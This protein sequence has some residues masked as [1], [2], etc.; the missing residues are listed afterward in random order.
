MNAACKFI[1]S[2][3]FAAG[4]PLLPGQSSTHYRL[5]AASSQPTMQT[6]QSTHYLVEGSLGNTCSRYSTNSMREIA[7]GIMIH[8][9]PTN[10]VEPLF[11]SD[12]D[13]L[14][15]GWEE[16]Y[17]GNHSPSASADPDGDGFTNTQ[18]QLAGTNPLDPTSL[19]RTT[20][21]TKSGTTINVS[22][23]GR[24]SQAYRVYFSSTLAAPWALLATVTTNASG[25]AS[26]PD[27]NPARTNL[28][29]GFYRIELVRDQ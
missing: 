13:G 2:L 27:T 24:V 7:A 1:P 8:R 12:G 17:F 15:D 3:L 5:E 29:K 25:T 16:F 18:E 19:F 28:A 26:Y 22:W 11:D 10:L 4:A 20:A 9:L 23:R 21:F 14:A 6:T